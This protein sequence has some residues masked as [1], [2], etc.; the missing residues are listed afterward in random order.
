MT[1]CFGNDEGCE[2]ILPNTVYEVFWNK[3]FILAGVHPSDGVHQGSIQKSRNEYYL[4][5]KSFPARHPYRKLGPYTA[6]QR[7]SIV[8]VYKIDLLKMERQIFED[9]K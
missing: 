6:S 8:K 9:L 4:I 1:I 3:N 7:D 5:N 2:G